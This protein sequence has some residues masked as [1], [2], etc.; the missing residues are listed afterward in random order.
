VIDIRDIENEL[1]S[2]LDRYQKKQEYTRNKEMKEQEDYLGLE[3]EFKNLFNSIV[4]PLMAQMVIYLET[5]GNEFKG[6]YV[7]VSPHLAK[8]A[9]ILNP[10]RLQQ[11][12]KWKLLNVKILMG[13]DTG[14]EKSYYKPTEQELLEDYLKVVDLL[15]INEINKLKLEFEEK[16]QI[17]KSQLEAIA[18]DVAFLKR[19]YNKSK[20]YT[21]FIE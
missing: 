19:K 20:A 11:G 5:K 16:Q 18:K 1:D 15:T 9:L 21:Y 13:H 8:I 3:N 4:K 7:K 12:S 17:E 2:V 14:L 6:S 10:Y